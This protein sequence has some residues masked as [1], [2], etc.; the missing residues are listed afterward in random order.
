MLIY[1]LI[2]FYLTVF[3]KQ[4]LTRHSQQLRFSEFTPE[5]VKEECCLPTYRA[6]CASLDGVAHYVIT[7][8]HLSLGKDQEK[9][10]SRTWVYCALS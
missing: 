1:F 3:L 8:V 7:N 4:L 10:R 6:P 5:N 2:Y 9:S